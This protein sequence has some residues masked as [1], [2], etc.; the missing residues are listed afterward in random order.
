[1]PDSVIRYIPEFDT[2]PD[3][4]ES[5]FRRL[6]I[7]FKSISGTTILKKN[8]ILISGNE[9][10][11]SVENFLKRVFKKNEHI[12]LYINNSIRPNLDDFIADLFDLYQIANS[13]NIS[14]SF[15]PAY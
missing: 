4:R 9:T 10:L 8:K 11:A 2:K 7:V 3:M 13:L 15:T 1:M 6:K 12:Y 5:L 14:Y